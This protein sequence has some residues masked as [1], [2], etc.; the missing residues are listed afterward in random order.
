MMKREGICCVFNFFSIIFYPEAGF[1]EFLAKF[2]FLLGIVLICTPVGIIF[3]IL[4]VFMFKS[5]KVRLQDSAQA[6]RYLEVSG[7]PGDG[8][9]L[10]SIPYSQVL[11]FEVSATNYYQ[12][13]LSVKCK[14]GQ[15]QI[16]CYGAEQQQLERQAELRKKFGIASQPQQQQGTTTDQSNTYQPPTVPPP[17]SQQ[18]PPQAYQQQPAV[19]YQQQAQQ[20]YQVPTMPIEKHDTFKPQETSSAFSHKPEA[21]LYNYQQQATMENASAPD[22]FMQ[23][24]AP[25]VYQQQDENVPARFADQQDNVPPRFADQQQPS[26][27]ADML[28]RFMSNN[29]NTTTT[30]TSSNMDVPAR[31]SDNDNA[32]RFGNMNATPSVYDEQDWTQRFANNK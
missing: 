12:H 17:S 14:Q 26:N 22:R 2:F 3:I 27:V 1:P 18:P 31:F 28:D 23:D 29:D 24:T 10:R 13:M 16:L 5:K 7:F 11:D 32:P 19:Y 9:V 4:S 15:D 20:S 8:T 30:T 25:Q 6:I 21:P